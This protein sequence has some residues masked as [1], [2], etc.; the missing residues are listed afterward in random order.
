MISQGGQSIRAEEDIGEIHIDETPSGL[1]IYVP[2]DA[3][4]QELCFASPLPINLAN[5]LMQDPTTQI[6]DCVDRSAITAL[7]TL[8]SVGPSAVNMILDRLGII[9][10]HITNEDAAEEAHDRGSHTAGFAGNDAI[11]PQRPM[12][13]WSSTSG[14]GAGDTETP[15]TSTAASD[16]ESMSAIVARSVGQHALRPPHQFT[17][18]PISRAPVASSPSPTRGAFDMAALLDALPQSDD[19]GD[20]DVAGF[21]GSDWS[22]GSD[23]LDGF[24][25]FDVFDGFDAVRRFRSSSRLERDKKIGAAGELYVSSAARR[26]FAVMSA[27]H[28]SRRGCCNS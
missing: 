11:P 7:T 6:C 14:S 25:G 21:G 19:D 20:G 10:I 23:K 18:V 28:V 8:L 26:P 15:A 16:N 27:E 3:T 22:D 17:P 2:M 5:W 9:Q 4:A 12:S 24:D 1:K 13:S